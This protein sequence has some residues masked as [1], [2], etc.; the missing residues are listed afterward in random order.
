MGLFS[1][2]AYIEDM[3]RQGRLP[4]VVG[5]TNYY[6]E[7]LLWKVLLDTGVSFIVI[8]VGSGK[9]AGP[10]EHQT[11]SERVRESSWIYPVCRPLCLIGVPLF[12]PEC[13]FVWEGAG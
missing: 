7:S 4:I 13:S 10:G 6:I 12:L 8:G 9:G 3:H 1:L 2:T 5:G 11:D